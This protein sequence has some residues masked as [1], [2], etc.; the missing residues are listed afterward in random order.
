MGTGLYHCI[1]TRVGRVVPHCVVS[2]PSACIVL[3][4]VLVCIVC[5]GVNVLNPSI[6]HRFTHHVSVE[7]PHPPPRGDRDHCDRASYTHRAMSSLI[8]V[9]GCTCRLHGGSDT[10]GTVHGFRHRRQLSYIRAADD[11]L[12]VIHSL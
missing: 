7:K 11:L 10:R 6:T 4:G 1:I 2:C 12:E 5:S 9:L 8:P 3:A